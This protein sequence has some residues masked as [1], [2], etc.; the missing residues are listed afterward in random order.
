MSE[1]CKMAARGGSLGFP[2]IVT[3]VL[4]ISVLI[5]IN[6]K[7]SLDNDVSSIFV[8]S[9]LDLRSYPSRNSGLPRRYRTTT[10][11]PPYL[12]ASVGIDLARISICAGYLVLLAGDISENP[13]PAARTLACPSCSKGIRRNQPTSSTMQAVRVELS[14]QM[15]WCRLRA[16]QFLSPV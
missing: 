15:P 7:G 16:N 1:L 11:L 4:L 9:K 14:S 12:K 2:L 6:P 10:R 5:T 3:F 8:A 13:G